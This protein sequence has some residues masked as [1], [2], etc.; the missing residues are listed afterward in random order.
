[1][2]KT[3]RPDAFVVGDRLPTGR[4][5]EGTSMEQSQT[6]S[7]PYDTVDLFRAIAAS[8]S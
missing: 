6:P 5:K 3:N 7:T 2:G 8:W 4:I 1:M